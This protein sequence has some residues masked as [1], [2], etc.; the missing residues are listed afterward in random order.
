MS[1]GEISIRLAPN[2]EAAG[3]LGAVQSMGERAHG[4]TDVFAIFKSPTAL[5]NAMA[6]LRQNHFHQTELSL[7][8]PDVFA[9]EPHPEDPTSTN[10]H[11]SSSTAQGVSTVPPSAETRVIVGPGRFI[12]AGPIKAALVQN[13]PGG[14]DGAMPEILRHFGL[15]AYESDRYANRIFGGRAFLSVRCRNYALAVTV[16]ELLEKA[17]GASIGAVRHRRRQRTGQSHDKTNPR[18]K[19]RRKKQP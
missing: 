15:P 1:K 5:R 4:T 3:A 9:E 8:A 18:T 12:V 13:G 16:T 14:P 7:L 2:H 11:Q 17:G 6:C 10:G 19:Q